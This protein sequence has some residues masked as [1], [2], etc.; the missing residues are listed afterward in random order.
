MD[1]FLN[2]MDRRNFVSVRAFTLYSA[3][4]MLY[5][6][7]QW[8]MSFASSSD[9]AGVEVSLIITAATGPATLLAGYV[10]KWYVESKAT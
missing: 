7:G 8:A 4:W 2:W 5:L 1:R 3:V 9:R 6:A 10:F